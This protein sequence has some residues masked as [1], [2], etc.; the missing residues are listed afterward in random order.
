V[1]ESAPVA[2][3]AGT[4]MSPPA[5]ADFQ[6]EPEL[7]EVQT[8]G[9]NVTYKVAGRSDIPSDGSPHK[10]MISE[11]T[12]EPDLDYL[13]IPKHATAVYRRI[14]AINQGPGPVLPGEVNLF[15]GD[16]FIG[17]NQIDFIPVGDEIE[18]HYGVEDRI[19]V[20]RELVKRE[21]DKTLLRDRRQLL[22]G[23]EIE[24]KNML[25]SA[26]KIEIH[27]Q[28][29]VS[30]HEEIKVRMEQASPELSE[31][32]ELNVMKWEVTMSPADKLKIR[33]EYQIQHPRTIRVVGLID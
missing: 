10:T 17:R 2:L 25:S 14:K 29:P 28:L 30:R 12:L 5:V 20:E 32:S 16:E 26:V 9:A 19:S 33:Y 27:D 3:S 13:T 4:A 22:Y 6:A 31:L 23:Y 24:L 11:L 21:V 8:E 1:A 18:L 7:A 15:F